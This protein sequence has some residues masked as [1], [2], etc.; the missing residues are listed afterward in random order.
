MAGMLTKRRGGD[1]GNLLAMAAGFVVVMIL[2]GL[3]N[4]VT[5]IF[6]G[7]GLYTQPAWLPVMEFP[8]W[9]MFGSLTT[10]GVAVCFRTPA[11]A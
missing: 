5:Q 2:S 8:W 11:R 4:Q 6:A 1:T 9:V 10:F 7:H 3:L